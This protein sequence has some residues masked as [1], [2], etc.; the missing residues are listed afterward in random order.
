MTTIEDCIARQDSTATILSASAI[1][2]NLPSVA[3]RAAQMDSDQVDLIRQVMSNITLPSSAIPE[4]A[5]LV[6]EDKWKTSLVTI[7]KKRRS[8][9]MHCDYL[10]R[11]RKSINRR[12]ANPEV[13]MQLLMEG[14]INKMKEVDESW[15]FHTPVNP[16]TVP[17][18]HK[19]VKNPIDLQTLREPVYRS[20]AAL[21]HGM[22]FLTPSTTK[23]SST[24]KATEIHVKS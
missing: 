21:D 13:A 19:I 5:K 10:K 8:G 15:P 11:P 6:P 14:I 1:D 20:L 22:A 24:R 2:T 4:W 23:R 17:D 9:V 18:Y 7:R 3:A 12:R 16:K